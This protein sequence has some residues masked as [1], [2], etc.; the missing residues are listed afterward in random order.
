MILELRR[1]CSSH[2]KPFRQQPGQFASR[3]T[4]SAVRAVSQQAAR[5]GPLGTQVKICGLTSASDAALAAEAGADLLG[6]LLWPKGK[7]SISNDTAKE[8]VAV[9][10]EH[11]IPAVAL[12]VDEDAASIESACMQTGA[13]YAQL[14]GD[15][16]R[17]ALVALPPTRKVIYVMHATPAGVLQTATPHALQQSMGRATPRFVSRC[18]RL[19]EHAVFVPF[20][21]LQP[22]RSLVNQLRYQRQYHAIPCVCAVVI[23]K[24]IFIK[25]LAVY[26]DLQ[27]Q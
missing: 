27:H 20:W 22:V 12:F 2:P 19:N 8:I 25:S 9:A 16:A 21:M 26:L 13:T 17:A 14:H 18:S 11:N 24:T 3:R 6:F 10:K 23:G 4:Y 1:C 5:S 15:K 7:R